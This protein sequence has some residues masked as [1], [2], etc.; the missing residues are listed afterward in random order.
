MIRLFSR[1]LSLC[2]LASAFIMLT[3]DVTRSVASAKLYFTPISEALSELAP[4][5]LALARDVIERH[6]PFIW[7]PLLVALMQLPAWVG[8]GA[9]G[10]LLAWMGKKPAPSFGFS[11]R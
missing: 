8:V 11:S 5:K 3:I 6:I 9:A 10:A 1:F 7:D 4:G 2:L